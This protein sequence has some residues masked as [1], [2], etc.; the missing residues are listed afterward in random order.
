MEN[1][2]RIKS[3]QDW[4]NVVQ[5]L[6]DPDSKIDVLALRIDTYKAIE[7]YRKKP[8]IVY[9]SQFIENLPYSIQNTINI[10]DVD[11]FIDMCGSIGKDKKEV[12]VLL[13]SPGGDPSATERIV[14]VL[15]NR[16][17]VVN[18]LVPHS[19]YSAAT[20]LALSGNEIILSLDAVLGPIDPQISGIPARQIK[21]GFEKIKEQIAK[22]GPSHLPAYIPMIEKYTIDLLE[23]CEDAEK[24]SRELVLNWLSQYMFANNNTEDE[25]IKNIEEAVNFF[26]D[27]ETHLIH[28]RP[29]PFKRISHLGLKITVAD[30]ILQELLREAYLLINGFFSIAPFA[31]LYETTNGINWGKQYRSPVNN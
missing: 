12:D 17:D 7:D 5:D 10:E 25:I 2:R 9:A 1:R 20:M 15:R 21:R 28:S 23:L 31:K 16:F 4:Q 13:H 18:F 22:D 3:V 19:A 8:L 11:G 27:Y 26:A 6:Q 24:L 14:D 29:L 30:D